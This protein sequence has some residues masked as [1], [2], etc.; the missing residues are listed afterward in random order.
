MKKLLSIIIAFVVCLSLAS[1]SADDTTSSGAANNQANRFTQEVTI[2]KMPSPPKCKTTSSSSV[3]NEVL[4]VLREIEKAPNTCGNTNGWQYMIKINIDGKD[5]SYSIASDT[6]TD[7]DGQQYTITNYNYIS[8]K[9]LSIYDKI[10]IPEM[11][12]T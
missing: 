4:E 8:E 2:V 6:F 11:D 10:D 7:S 5:L 12:Y 9:I 1:C 3:V